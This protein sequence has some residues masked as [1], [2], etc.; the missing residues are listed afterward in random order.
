MPAIRSDG[1]EF[2]VELAITRI[3]EQG[4]PLFTGYVRDIS[5][6]KRAEEHLKF[7]SHASALFGS[8]LD[9]DTTMK[10]IVKLAVPTLADWAVVD[11][12]SRESDQPYRRVA[13]VHVDPEKTELA[14]E[15]RRKYPPDPAKDRIL[16]AIQTGQSELVTDVPEEL[17]R[18]ASHNEEHFQLIKELGIVSWMIVPLRYRD[19]PIGAVTFVSSDSRRRFTQSDLANAE[20]FA[21]RASTAFENSRLY[22]EAQQA[23]R[24]KD[25]FLATLSHELRTPMTSI[26]GW[27]RMLGEHDLDDETYKTAIDS[28]QRSATLQ[29]ELIEDVLD[30]SRIASGKM[31]LDVQMCDLGEITDAAL[32]TVEPAAMAKGITI[33]VEKSG[34]AIVTGDPKRLQQV[35]WNLLTNAIKFTPR[36]GSV[37]VS[38]EEADSMAQVTVSDTGQ[39]FAREFGAHLFEPFRQAESATT[40]THGGLGLGLSIVR[41]L[42][43]QHGGVVTAESPGSGQGAT[44]R[45]RFPLRALKVDQRGDGMRPTRLASSD[46]QAPCRK[47][48]LQHLRILFVDDQEDARTL[49]RTILKRCGASVTLAQSVD[50]G[51]ELFEKE[52]F[53]LVVTDIAMPGKD[54]FEL[55]AWLNRRHDRSDFRIVALTAFGGPEDREKVLATGCEAYL[56]KPVEPAELVATIERVTERESA[57]ADR[58]VDRG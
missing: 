18:E 3:N 48:E 24:A 11:L 1:S 37:H 2:A 10:N 42:V 35:I 47:D 54:G 6:R 38:V 15:L 29:A 4:P 40:R 16:R 53:D 19:V 12:A 55:I 7:L 25:N 41:Y 28:I 30:M 27:A 21:R 58:R 5:E 33:D 22:S 56:K 50:E 49:F 9:F 44:F 31:R 39:G 17:L 57:G 20:E 23:N 36:D 52:R 32:A 46:A 43:E 45:V 8:S 14:M 34:P 51:I 13:V 26:L